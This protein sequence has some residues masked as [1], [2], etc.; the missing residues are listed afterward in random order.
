MI[1]L[2]VSDFIGVVDTP[3]AG[4]CVFCRLED[5]ESAFEGSESA[6]SRLRFPELCIVLVALAESS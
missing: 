1:C 2:F 5:S 4:E 3:A 6:W